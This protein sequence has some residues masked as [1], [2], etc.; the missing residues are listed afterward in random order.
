MDKISAILLL[1]PIS[2][3]LIK[4]N[5]SE[6]GSKDIIIVNSFNEITEEIIKACNKVVILDSYLRNVDSYS[7]IRLFKALLGIE[8]IILGGNLAED[9][10]LSLYGD[11]FEC[12]Y[13]NLD[14][15]MIQS[16]VF[17]DSNAESSSIAGEGREDYLKFANS[18]INSEN[19]F[20]SQIIDLA[21]QF[22]NEHNELLSLSKEFKESIKQNKLL[23]NINAKISIENDRLTAQF[24][25]MM[26]NAMKLNK[27]L[28]EYE[29]ILSQDVYTKLSLSNYAKKPTVIYLKEI[30]MLNHET[31]FI[32]V[33][34]EMLRMQGKQSVKVLRLYDSANCRQVKALPSYY[35]IFRNG[36]LVSDVTNNDFIA[37]VGDYNEILDILL[38]NKTG[39]DILII[40]DCK[41]F[42]DTV[43]SGAQLYF[44]LCSD[45]DHVTSYDLNIENTII[46]GK[47]DDK[48]LVWG[49]YE[50]I[51][52]LTS[53]EE[54]FLF[55]SSRPIMQT[56]YALYHLT[57]NSV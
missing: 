2:R 41:G 23:Q 15:T 29:H 30:E 35:K 50:E 7:N 54:V 55:L 1:D 39:L 14:Y 51:A 18:I 13:T 8:L 3:R 43:V 48:L 17:Q 45:V 25:S 37:K 9:S 24:A 36:F 26:K 38:T 31:S 33:L 52:N 22:I 42:D 44:N 32:E 5:V 16:A 56:I 40:V 12:D 6:I 27:S 20:E 34:F 53:K 47:E 4:S 57:V 46:N 49:E 11:V 28:T 21:R 10:T 19:L